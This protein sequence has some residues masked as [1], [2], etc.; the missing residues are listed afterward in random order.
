MRS[1]AGVV[2]GAVLGAPSLPPQARSLSPTTV[3]H[4]P[5][6]RPHSWAVE[7][8]QNVPPRQLLLIGGRGSQGFSVGPQQELCAGHAACPAM[9]LLPAL[10]EI[11]L[12]PPPPM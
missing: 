2:G 6:S 1:T 7:I 3:A 12:I 10:A 8:C 4:S 11:P 9:A 5:S